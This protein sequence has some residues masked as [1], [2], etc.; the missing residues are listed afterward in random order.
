MSYNQG[1]VEPKTLQFEGIKVGYQTQL[2]H[3]ITQEDVVAFS[4]LTGDFNPL[5][6]DA[7]FA[8]QT[9]FGKPIVH[10]MLTS[11]FISTM[12]GML[13][14]GS[15][16]L[17]VSQTLEFLVPAYVGDTIKVIAQVKRKSQAT[18]ILILDI[19][20]INQHESKLVTGESNVRMM[21]PDFHLPQEV[22]ESKINVVREP[23]KSFSDSKEIVQS[24]SSNTEQ[25]VALVT[26]GSRGI[27][28]A[29][30]KKLASEGH[31]VIINYLQAEEEANA[32]VGEI[33]HQGGTAISVQGDVSNEKDVENI[34][35]KAESKFGSVQ[36]VLHCAA[37]NPIPQ[38]F[39][40]LQWNTQQKHWDIQVK[41]AFNCTKRALPQ[42]IR[43]KSGVF[44]FL[45]SIFVDGTPPVQQSAYVVAKAALTALARSLA[46]EYGPKGIRVNTV[47]PGLTHTEMISNIPEKVKM[48]AKMNTPLR[49]LAEPNDIASVIT[50]LLSPAARHITGENLRVCG[51]LVMS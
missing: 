17:W 51:G 5:H 36:S 42:M 7:E 35:S 6:V 13:L 50:F 47:S 31:A 12:I 48:L 2:L 11:S 38:S 37:P 15:G 10:G 34:F 26:G 18:K 44:V 45:G 24:I 29:S 40:E 49:R 27:G 23:L 30:V 16:S 25:N 8:R 41:G 3:T 22:S 39:E 1:D 20:V 46:V 21:A 28:A 43:E 19:V 9:S 32:L 33:I 4:N 14:P